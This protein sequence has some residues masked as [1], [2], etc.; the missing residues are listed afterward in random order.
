MKRSIFIAGALAL[1]VALITEMSRENPIMGGPCSEF[2]FTDGGWVMEMQMFLPD[3][4]D[5]WR[6]GGKSDTVAFRP[7]IAAHQ[8]MLI[9]EES[10]QAPLTYGKVSDEIMLFSPQSPE[11]LARLVYG[12]VPGAAIAAPRRGQSLCY[13]DGGDF[14]YLDNSPTLGAPNDEKNA[15]GEVRGTVTDTLGN[16]IAQ[17]A[18]RYHDWMGYVVYTDSEGHYAFTD[19]AML[20]S[21]YFEHPAYVS[22]TR[23]Q[24]VWPESTV[25]VSVVMSRLVSVPGDGLHPEAT[26][27]SVNYPNPFNPS[28]TFDLHLRRA[29]FVSVR[30]YTLTGDEVA[31]LVEANLNPGIHRL[32]WNAEGLSSGV[33]LCCLKA[34]DRTVTRKVL[35][36]R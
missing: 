17:V 3:T 30:V 23:T 21:I 1:A 31:R 35:L 22:V 5:G 20:Q 10:L 12:G 28:T 14:Y 25:E 32:H 8:F 2:M 9:T 6:L 15:A 24:Q 18:V 4:L 34:A 13:R 29:G 11:P 7:G 19:Y 36:V 33:Y 16:P 26:T 27:L